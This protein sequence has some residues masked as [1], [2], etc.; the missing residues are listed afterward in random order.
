MIDPTDAFD[1]ADSPD[2]F[3]MFVAATYYK[4]RLPERP[5]FG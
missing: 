1:N 4:M 5:E 3:A 2:A